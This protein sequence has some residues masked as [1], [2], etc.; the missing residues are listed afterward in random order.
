M[1]TSAKVLSVSQLNGQIKYLIEQNFSHIWL[2]GEISNLVKASSGHWYFSLKDDKAQVRCAMFKSANNRVSFPVKDGSQILLRAN[3]SLYQ[4][5]GEFQLVVESMQ[6]AG[7]GKLQL[8]FEALKNK[9]SNE[10]LF[11][12]DLKQP[13]PANI[14]RVAVVTSAKGAAIHDIISILARRAPNIEV[15]IYPCL[16]QGENAAMD[17]CQKLHWASEDNKCDVIIVGRGGGSIEDL[18]AFNNETL[19][20]TIHQIDKCVISAVG[21]ETDFTIC[22]FVA[23]IRAA[24]P[25]AA[26]ELVSQTSLDVQT[27]LPHLQHKLEHAMQFKINE[28]NH[29]LNALQHQLTRLNPLNQIQLKQQWLDEAELRLAQK[30]NAQLHRNHTKLVSL[31]QRLAEHNPKYLLSRQQQQLSYLTQNLDAKIE[32]VLN[33]QFDQ[34]HYLAQQ[35]NTLSPL[36]T[37][38]RGFSITSIHGKAVKSIQQV[39]VGDKLEHKV[40]DGIIHSQII[41]KT[42]S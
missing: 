37:L 7:V 21:H 9:L 4:P 8:E 1:S 28:L 13:L 38:N 23:D 40:A 39:E 16:V 34:L 24:T 17:I 11:A 25:S 14:S 12:A 15:E 5:R 33:K 31:Q 22:D 18:W 20:Y 36:N 2:E 19:A 29:K 32:K 6:P 41:S 27:K 42:E 35:L 10:G 26:A 3:A 30:L